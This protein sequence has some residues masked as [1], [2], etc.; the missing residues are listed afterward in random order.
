MTAPYR[1][2]YVQFPSW[3]KNSTFKEMV[4][5][6]LIGLVEW[7]GH[8]LVTLQ[9]MHDTGFLATRMQ[10]APVQMQ[11]IH[12]RLVAWILKDEEK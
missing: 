12:D 5:S 1:L 3:N 6:F 4:M 11:E 8:G 7:F 2:T 10:T 9:I